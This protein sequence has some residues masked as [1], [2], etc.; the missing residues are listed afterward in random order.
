[1]S[2]ASWNLYLNLAHASLGREYLQAASVFFRQAEA[3][4]TGAKDAVYAQIGYL[5]G[6]FGHPKSAVDYYRKALS[7]ASEDLTIYNRLCAAYAQAGEKDDLL[8]FLG[9]RDVAPEVQ[10]KGKDAYAVLG[11]VLLVAGMD[12]AAE[13][14]LKEGGRK[15][16][17][18]PRRGGCLG[19][20]SYAGGALGRCAGPYSR[21]FEVS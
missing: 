11:I 15:N 4:D 7:E 9:Q 12:H 19:T 17:Y 6:D 13:R 14:Y 3:L 8:S 16:K 5:Y 21:R 10:L 1:M 2:E 18:G 20:G